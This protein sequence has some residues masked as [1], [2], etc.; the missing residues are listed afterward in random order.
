MKQPTNVKLGELL[1]QEGFLTPEQL[2]LAL[3]AQKGREAYVP[4]GEVCIELE[5]LSRSD[6]EKI[7]R[8]HRKRIPLGE[9]LTNLG[10]ITPEHLQ[11]ALNQQKTGEK[12][13]VGKIL[14][15]GLSHKFLDI[16]I[17]PVEFL[18]GVGWQEFPLHGLLD[19]IAPL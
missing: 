5:L 16:F 9:L 18:P 2:A 10:L 7:L 13:R 3:A 12:K 8:T 19:A 6:L 4:L 17:M 14:L 11:E 1:I 15:S